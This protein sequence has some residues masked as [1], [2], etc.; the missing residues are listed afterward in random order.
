M[1]HSSKKWADLRTIIEKGFE[2]SGTPIAKLEPKEERLWS[3]S[4]PKTKYVKKKKRYKRK[5]ASTS[6][7]KVVLGSTTSLPNKPK[8]VIKR[9]SKSAKGGS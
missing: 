7:A 8:I 2:L 5:R 9:K 1:M 4:K 6:R 3:V